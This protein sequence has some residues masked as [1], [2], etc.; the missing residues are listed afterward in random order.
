MSNLVEHAKREFFHAGWC[1]KDDKFEDEMQKIICDNILE[2]LEVFSNQ[3]HTGTTAPY[4]MRLFDQLGKYNPIGPL[5][6][7]DDEWHEIAEDASGKTFQNIRDS[8]VFKSTDLGGN[9]DSIYWIH[10]KAFRDPNN[11]QYTNRESR[12]DI[13]FPWTKPKTIIVD[14]TMFMKCLKDYSMD[15]DDVAFTK[16]TIYEFCRVDNK[17]CSAFNDFGESHPIEID[18]VFYQ[19]NF[20]EVD[21][22]QL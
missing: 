8:E 9:V 17:T 16:N 1:D 21:E 19:N 12:V 15:N 10:G 5:S 18:V 2:L 14:R 3:G 6:G 20:V 13:V 4:V 7:N 11:Q 22:P